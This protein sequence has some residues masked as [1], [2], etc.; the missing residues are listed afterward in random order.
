MIFEADKPKN[1]WQEAV[2]YAANLCNRSATKINDILMTP[3]EAF[4][5][6]KPDVTELQII[7]SPC[8]VLDQSGKHGKLD[9]KTKPA[10]F[11]G[12]AENEGRSYWY[13][14]P[15]GHKVLHSR[16]VWFPKHSKTAEH[17]Q[18]SE[19]DDW[20]LVSL[21]D[22][23]NDASKTSSLTTSPT[24]SLVKAEK[25]DSKAAHTL[26]AQTLKTA[27]KQP[28]SSPPPKPTKQSKVQF[29]AIPFPVPPPELDNMQTPTELAPMD[30]SPDAVQQSV[31][32]DTGYRM[33]HQTEGTNVQQFRLK[34]DRGQGQVERINL[35]MDKFNEMSLG[36][37][38]A[39][40]CNSNTYPNSEDNEIVKPAAM[41]ELRVYTPCRRTPQVAVDSVDKPL[42]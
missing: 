40:Y 21:L 20:V 10:I 1:L 11:A 30:V 34:S 12:I 39:K 17:P 26:A 14:T 13:I 19:E 9:P 29:S 3:Y 15:G 16:N 18:E 7:G 2:A 5:G 41:I 25:G 38:T 24:T 35:L 8:H 36:V 32:S 28:A 37:E 23:E 27:A 42:P 33:R 6:K 31:V 4:F 22:G